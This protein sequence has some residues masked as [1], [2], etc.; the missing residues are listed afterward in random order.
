MNR[1]PHRMQIR[2]PASLAL[3][4][5][6]ALAPLSA[7]MAQADKKVLKDLGTVIALQGHPCGK[8]TKADKKGENDYVVT[9]ESGDKYRVTI[10]KNDRVVVKKR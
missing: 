4:G 5:L 3:A 1:K 2:M 6:L 10:D 8:A 9:C 7:A